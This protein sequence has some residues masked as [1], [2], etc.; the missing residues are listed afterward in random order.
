MTHPCRRLDRIAQSIKAAHDMGPS[1]ALA[2]A[3]LNAEDIE[4]RPERIKVD[5]TAL[6]E[7]LKAMRPSSDTTWEFAAGHQSRTR[8]QIYRVARDLGIRVA[9]K[10]KKGPGVFSV[11][12]LGVGEQR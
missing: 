9:L 5:L 10:T 3:A 12:C 11:K 7:A 2:G 1:W 6:T 4:E 8:M